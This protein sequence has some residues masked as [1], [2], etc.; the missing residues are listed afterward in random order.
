MK[1]N[2]NRAHP[3]HGIQTRDFD[4]INAYIEMVP[5]DTVKYELDKET[6]LLKID[7]PQLYSSQL[8]CLYGFIPQT[9]CGKSV[10]EYFRQQSV[11]K[12]QT[13][14][15]GDEDPLDV[16]VLTSMVIPRGDITVKV[17]PIGG[18][19][20]SDSRQADDKI[21]AILV[22]DPVYGDMRTLSDLSHKI[23]DKITHYF[24]TYKDMPGDTKQN[25]VLHGDYEKMEANDVI[26]AAVNDYIREF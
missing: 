21:I 26:T 18:I 15:G 11:C 24:L 19:R 23:T 25:I 20:L 22:D 12:D 14:L 7:R 17:L 4:G 5:T 2:V 9:Y 1:C 16:C 13:I 3:W 8:P 6:G 10:A